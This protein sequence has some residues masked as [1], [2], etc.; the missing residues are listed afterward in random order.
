ML[1][2]VELINMW[3]E[4]IRLTIVLFFFSGFM[5]YIWVYHL[6]KEMIIDKKDFAN[7]YRLILIIFLLI[8]PF[9]VVQAFYKYIN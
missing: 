6:I 8:L 7:I 1:T 3:N 9:L 2:A 5:A 4:N